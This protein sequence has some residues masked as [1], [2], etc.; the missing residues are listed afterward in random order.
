MGLQG[1]R[2]V[3]VV[4]PEH[5]EQSNRL[6]NNRSII[7]SINKQHRSNVEGEVVSSVVVVVVML[8]GALRLLSP[9]PACLNALMPQVS[10][11][12][13][14][15]LSQRRHVPSELEIQARDSLSC[16][17]IVWLL[18]WTGLTVICDISAVW[19]YDFYCFLLLLLR[20]SQRSRATAT[21]TTVHRPRSQLLS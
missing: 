19:K 2:I 14:P 15:A 5:S 16:L 1:D 13:L 10:H 9:M 20:Q 4:V 3:I 6:I 21:T 11:P 8:P 17:V 12:R 7:D 18:V